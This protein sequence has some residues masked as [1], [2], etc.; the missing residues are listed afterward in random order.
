MS[1]KI[2][3]KRI[4]TLEKLYLIFGGIETELE[5]I[6]STELGIGALTQEEH[7]TDLIANHLKE[8]KL[9]PFLINVIKN[10][11]NY[12]DK[13]KAISALLIVAEQE[14]L[15]SILSQPDF[16]S[17]KSIQ[18]A[19]VEAIKEINDT[20]DK[21]KALKALIKSAEPKDL[22]AIFSQSD[23]LSNFNQQLSNII[24]KQTIDNTLKRKT[25]KALRQIK[26]N[27]DKI[28]HIMIAALDVNDAETKN[29]AI[30][31][32][33][34]YHK[35]VDAN[36][37]TD[38]VNTSELDLDFKKDLCADKVKMSSL[39]DLLEKFNNQESIDHCLKK[40]KEYLALI[41]YDNFNEKNPS[42]DLL[43]KVPTNIKKLTKKNN[44]EEEDA[45]D[46]IKT[47][48]T[49]I[50]NVQ[51]KQF[52][53]E[54]FFG[55]IKPFAASQDIQAT[56]GVNDIE[57]F[58]TNYKDK[59]TKILSKIQYEDPDS[60]NFYKEYI[61][62]D[63]INTIPNN[64]KP[65]SGHF[66]RMS[67]GY[68]NSWFDSGN[69]SCL[70][71]KSTTKKNN[72]EFLEKILNIKNKATF[73]G[74]SNRKENEILC[75][76]D[77]IER[78][79]K[80]YAACSSESSKR[81][82]RQAFY[83]VLSDLKCVDDTKTTKTRW[84]PP[85][86]QKINTIE[87]KNELKI[88]CSK[89]QLH[90]LVHAKIANFRYGYSQNELAGTI[91]K[92]KEERLPSEINNYCEKHQKFLLQ[93]QKENLNILCIKISTSDDIGYFS[94]GLGGATRYVF[95]SFIYSPSRK[96]ANKAANIVHYYTPNLPN[97]SIEQ[98]DGC[99]LVNP[100]EVSK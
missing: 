98:P 39:N 76:S 73:Q 38:L 67:W 56:I 42:I 20:D 5:R 57:K 10:T 13:K 6:T 12:D 80:E 71:L 37:I 34:E 72:N 69:Y 97:F 54:L 15:E 55:K 53:L 95:N 24:T 60:V 16:L 74:T 30:Y 66:S 29:E 28:A 96:A 44:K 46:S 49:N 47:L 1:F 58:T 17:N 91:K 50:I 45:L 87:L 81:E 83:Q 21:Q 41:G 40:A 35:E 86:C 92:T 14:D 62:A 94:G 93:H 9:H 75:D 84:L 26:G 11:T 31:F 27:D 32:F 8:K 61:K 90:L 33:K 99:T 64:E 43:Y 63:F 22:K 3:Q 48:V 36:L 77:A 68:S 89:D 70:Y 78:I 2:K 52:V 82:Y 59:L 18:K 23:F 19:L 4:D 65:G 100:K 79:V 51:Q 85:L 25:I 88:P 7:N